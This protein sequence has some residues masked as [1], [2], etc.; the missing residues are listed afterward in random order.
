MKVAEEMEAKE[1]A[2]VMPMNYWNLA[3]GFLTPQQ[4]VMDITSF[5]VRV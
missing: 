1:E 2:A 4:G 3:C 5:F